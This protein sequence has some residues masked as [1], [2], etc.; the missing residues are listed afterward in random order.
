[1]KK[2]LIILFLSNIILAVG[3]DVHFSQFYNSPLTI[4][5]AN[6]GA[7][8]GD[9]RAYSNYRNQ[10]SS[11]QSA[12][13]TYSFSVESQL[14]KYKWPNNYLGIGLNFFNDKAGDLGLGL[15]QTNLTV[16]SILALSPDL[17]MTVGIQPS[18][19]QYSI[20][21]TNALTS[22][23]YVNGGFNPN[24]P[25]GETNLNNGFS[26][27]DV[28]TGCTFNYARGESN[29]ASHDM[30]IINVGFSFSHVNRSV[31]DFGTVEE[32]Y[33]K[34]IAHGNSNIG[35]VNSKLSIM[36]SYLV[37]LQGPQKE[38]TAGSM[39]RLFITESSR[40]T[41]N[42]SESAILFGGHYRWKDALI[43][44]LGYQLGEYMIQIS[45]DINLSSLNR[46]TRYRGGF[47]ISLKYT[48]PEIFGAGR[49]SSLD[50]KFM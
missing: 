4:N 20:D 23:Q 34:I 2:I 16:S 7:F 3:Q 13:K 19:M 50:P 11:I 40:Y 29:I 25:T 6:A 35:I 10:W 5:P 33:P 37:V 49:S 14:L 38:I 1:M 42:I 9:I 8:N 28:S 31:L 44:S 39:V 27:F 22:S 21:Y 24:L 17:T 15:S 48:N 26:F 36:P 32:L 30:L 41:G 43:A 18:Y 45:Y 12:Y 46:S 47:E